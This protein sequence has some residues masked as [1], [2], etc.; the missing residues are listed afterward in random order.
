MTFSDEWSF[1]QSFTHA[2]KKK[3]WLLY[4]ENKI[5]VDKICRRVILETD[6]AAPSL[7]SDLLILYVCS[8]FSFSEFKLEGKIFFSRSG[9]LT[10]NFKNYL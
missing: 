6:L 1:I 2:S 9:P 3:E 4:T 7:I 8:D 10:E 5:T